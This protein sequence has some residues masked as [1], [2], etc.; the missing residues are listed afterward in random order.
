MKIAIIIGF[1]ALGANVLFLYSALV[2]GKEAD[3]AMERMM[4]QAQLR[5]KLSRSEKEE[6]A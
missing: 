1:V 2:L 6:E 3:E 4:H 5:D